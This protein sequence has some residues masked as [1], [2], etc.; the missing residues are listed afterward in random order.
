MAFR[1]DGIGF[2][3]NHQN[4]G[5]DIPVDESQYA[6]GLSILST[7][8]Q[9]LLTDLRANGPQA[10]NHLGLDHVKIT[11]IGTPGIG[12]LSSYGVN[13]MPT[14]LFLEQELG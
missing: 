1:Q 11:G 13:Y 4:A 6:F 5:I 9:Q 12:F 14:R 2:I 7:R 8:F 3:N 10:N